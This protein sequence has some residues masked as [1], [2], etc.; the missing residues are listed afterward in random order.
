MILKNKNTNEEIEMTYLDFRQKLKAEIETAFGN[1]RV[2]R[3]KETFYNHSNN[4]TVELN[5][6]FQLKFNFNDFSKS[7]WVIEEL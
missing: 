7:D 2:A 4:H 5:F 6:Y 1:Y 3:L